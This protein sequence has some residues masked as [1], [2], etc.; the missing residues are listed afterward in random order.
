[1]FGSK[2]TREDVEEYIASIMLPGETVQA[3][4]IA[5]YN[6]L[7]FAVVTSHRFIGTAVAQSMDPIIRSVP[8]DRIAAISVTDEKELELGR[9]NVSYLM[10][11][12]QGDVGSLSIMGR[13]EGAALFAVYEALMHRVCNVGQPAM[14]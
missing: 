4:H 6:P 10:V 9:G 13:Q 5:G 2:R 11:H 3:V 12:P 1:M 7:E 14:A 8:F